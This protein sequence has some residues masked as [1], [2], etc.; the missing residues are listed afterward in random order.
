MLLCSQEFDG[1]H[2]HPVTWSIFLGAMV[3]ER[4]VRN[5]AVRS[6]FHWASL[7]GLRRATSVATVVA[8]LLDIGVRVLRLLR[9]LGTN[10]RT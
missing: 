3:K 5:G 8:Q 2:H 1:L 9:N 4:Y 10:L 7:E 6:S